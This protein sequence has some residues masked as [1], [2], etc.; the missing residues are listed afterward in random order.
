MRSAKKQYMYIYICDLIETDLPFLTQC[1]CH[2]L[3][4]KW[5]VNLS[6]PKISEFHSTIYSSFSSPQPPSLSLPLPYSSSSKNGPL[7]GCYIMLTESQH[8]FTFNFNSMRLCNSFFKLVS[9]ICKSFCIIKNCSYRLIKRIGF[10]KWFK[11]QH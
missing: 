4:S 3:K 9:K 6:K 8:V 7:F 10:R 11:F 1:W 2:Y 5:S